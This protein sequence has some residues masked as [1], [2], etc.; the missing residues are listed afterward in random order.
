MSRRRTL[1]AL[2]IAATLACAPLVPVTHA[3]DATAST[4]GTSETVD[5]RFGVIMA[6]SCGGAA[7]I[8]TAL[9]NPIS[10]AITMIACMAMVIDALVTP[11]QP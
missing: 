3:Q 5:S 1:A 7:R 8:T 9:P 6:V 10:L 4:E 2:L 11:D